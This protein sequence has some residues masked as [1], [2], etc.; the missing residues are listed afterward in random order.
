MRFYALSF[1]AALSLL[2]CG[3]NLVQDRVQDTPSGRPQP[4]KPVR[5][6]ITPATSA[7]LSILKL[8]PDATSLSG[9]KSS[10]GAVS[11]LAADVQCTVTRGRELGIVVR[12]RNLML[13][14]TLAEYRSPRMATNWSG[15]DKGTVTF[16]D[17]VAPGEKEEVGPADATFCS[18]AA[19]SD[20]KRTEGTLRC[21][22]LEGTAKEGKIAYS[23]LMHFNCAPSHP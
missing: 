10:G 7:S 21:T 14:A 8:E 2:A 6:V 12:D 20:T 5:K 13:V 1:F 11:R 15:N 19:H 4:R 3:E 16:S 22:R 17:E 23:L 18:V 9:W